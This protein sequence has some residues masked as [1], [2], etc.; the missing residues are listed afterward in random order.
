MDVGVQVRR[1]V[2]LASALA[3]MLAGNAW[4]QGVVSDQNGR[5]VTPGASQRILSLGPDITE[6]VY[7]LGGADKVIARDRS[8][9]YPEAATAKLDVGYRRTLS[10]ESLVGLMPDLILAAEDIGPP[11]TVDVLKDLEIP[12]VT[13]PGNNTPEGI[14]RKIDI[15]AAILDQNDAGVMLKKQVLDD[16]AAAEALGNSIPVSERK[17]VV[18]FHG[19][20]RLTGA[21]NNTSAGSIIEFSGGINPLNEYDGYKAISEESLLALAPDVVLMLS[22]GKGGPTPEEV[23][24]NPALALTPAGINKALIVLEGPYM[25]GFG[26]RTSQAVRDLAVALYPELTGLNPR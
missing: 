2:F 18:F 17:K 9:R 25:L 21:G 7:V 11:E 10:P 3:C 8:S 5:A 15:I 13:V 16:F 4:A 19:L 1:V 22:D 24:A 26:P 20:L 23:F 12:M 6:I 14:A